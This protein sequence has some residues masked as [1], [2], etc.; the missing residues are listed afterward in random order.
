[1]RFR[2]Y[3]NH[4]LR[5]LIAYL[6]HI[7]LKHNRQIR[8]RRRYIQQRLELQRILIGREHKGKTNKNFR[9]PQKRTNP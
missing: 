2:T 8:L 3:R 1:M 4:K 9:S 6:E 7:K 5:R